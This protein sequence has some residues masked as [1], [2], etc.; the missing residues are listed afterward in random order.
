MAYWT[1]LFLV[2]CAI[3]ALFGY[4]GLV[5]L[6]RAGAAQALSWAF[7]AVCVVSFLA[8]LITG[9]DDGPG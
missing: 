1:L 4:G 6:A 2:L 9:D 8:M 5:P 3:A 7:G